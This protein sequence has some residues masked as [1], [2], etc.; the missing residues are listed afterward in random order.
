MCLRYA[1][2]LQSATFLL[3]W[4][5][6]FHNRH[7]SILCSFYV[8][9]ASSHLQIPGTQ[10]FVHYLH[11]YAST[12]PPY[13]W[14]HALYPPSLISFRL[15][16]EF[17]ASALHSHITFALN[18]AITSLTLMLIFTEREVVSYVFGSK[19]LFSMSV[20]D[21]DVHALRGRHPLGL[22]LCPWGERL[23]PKDKMGRQWKVDIF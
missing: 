13:L 21:N 1:Y 4:T 12:T 11:C 22:F 8:S 14:A 6:P 2:I 15:E 10:Y 19:F 23:W 20:L 18:G 9:L 7:L 5:V 3:T 16:Y 17:Y